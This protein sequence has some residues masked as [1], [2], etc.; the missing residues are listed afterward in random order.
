MYDKQLTEITCTIISRNLFP[1]FIFLCLY[2]CS[3]LQGSP[4]PSL[5]PPSSHWLHHSSIIAYRFLF[6]TGCKIK[7]YCKCSAELKWVLSA[8]KTSCIG[9]IICTCSNNAS[10]T[11]NVCSYR[12]PFTVSSIVRSET[13]MILDLETIY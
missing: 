8:V 9:D 7:W 6:R 5:N 10:W 11:S 12:N 2:S 4:Q 3:Y 1:V 13:V